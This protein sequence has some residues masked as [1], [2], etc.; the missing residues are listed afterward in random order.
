M[1]IGK[2]MM[3]SKKLKK[4]NWKLNSPNINNTQ[5]KRFNIKSELLKINKNRPKLKH[6]TMMINNRL[7]RILQKV[8][9]L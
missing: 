6:R 5:E 4:D 2:C 3:Q 8:H 1:L 9:K 7:S